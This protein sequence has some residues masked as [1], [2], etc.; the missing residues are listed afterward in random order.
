MSS[1][2]ETSVPQQC[3]QIFFYHCHTRHSTERFL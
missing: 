1:A 3:F 2:T